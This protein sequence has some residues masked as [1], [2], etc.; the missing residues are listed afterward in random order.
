MLVKKVLTVTL[1]RKWFLGTSNGK[2]KASKQTSRLKSRNLK[3]C[4]Q[5]WNTFRLF[6]FH[7]SY[8][9]A[10][11]ISFYLLWKFLPGLMFSVH[12]TAVFRKNALKCVQEWSL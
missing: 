4:V 8:A 2:G 10:S 11:V 3:P 6:D 5:V 9:F 1:C 7:V 12:E